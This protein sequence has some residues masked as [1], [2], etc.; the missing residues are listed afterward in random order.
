MSNSWIVFDD[1]DTDPY[2]K[3]NRTDNYKE[4]FLDATH[5]YVKSMFYANEASL[6][7]NFA[8]GSTGLACLIESTR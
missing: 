1:V 4:R 6:N 5:E 2:T 7:L 8:Y 3:E